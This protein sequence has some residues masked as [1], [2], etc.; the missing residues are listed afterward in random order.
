MQ[1]ERYAVYVHI[2]NCGRIFILPSDCEQGF[3]INLIV[4]KRYLDEILERNGILLFS[5]DDSDYE[6]SKRV[7]RIIALINS[8]D[9]QSQLVDTHPQVHGYEKS[10]APYLSETIEVAETDVEGL[11]H[12]LTEARRKLKNTPKGSN[13]HIKVEKHYNALKVRLAMAKHCLSQIRAL[14]FD[15]CIKTEDL[16]MVRE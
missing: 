1:E 11:R 15:L 12:Y 6:Q 9:F 16:P 7:N 3:E 2:Y 4:F 13:D 14:Y 10:F 8:Y 5:L